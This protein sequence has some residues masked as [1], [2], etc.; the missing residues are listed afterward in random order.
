MSYLIDDWDNYD[1]EVDIF[2]GE[3]SSNGILDHEHHV[4]QI[5]QENLIVIFN[6]RKFQHWHGC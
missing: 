3:S 5:D 6:S 2:I 4:I 1:Q